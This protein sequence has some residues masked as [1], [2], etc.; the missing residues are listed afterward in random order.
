MEMFIMAITEV[1]KNVAL[2]L[3][4]LKMGK[5]LKDNGSTE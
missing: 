4:I 2:E 5:N 1:T 3:N